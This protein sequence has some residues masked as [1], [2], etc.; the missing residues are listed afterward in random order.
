MRICVIT[1]ENFTERSWI[2]REEKILR[3]LGFDVNVIGLSDEKP[4]PLIILEFRKIIKELRT[5]DIAITWFAL[6]SSI[7]LSSALG[8]P[9][10]ANSV[11]YEVTCY[12]GRVNGIPCNPIWRAL[13]IYALRSADEIIAISK[14]SLKWAHIWS[15]RKGFVI[16][17]G[18][19]I[20]SY[21]CN[22]SQYST[23]INNR[24]PRIV[25]ISFLGIGNIIRKDI[26]TL[27]KAVSLVKKTYPNVKLYIIGKKMEGYVLLEKIARILGV[28]KNVIFTDKVSHEKLLEILCSSDVFVMTSWHEGFPTAA[29]EAAAAGVPV[30]VS[31]RPAMNEVFSHRNAI[32]VPPGN[33][34]ELAQAIIRLLSDKQLAKTLSLQAKETVKKF[35]IENR[36]INLSKFLILFIR[37]IYTNKS[38]LKTYY[39]VKIHKLFVLI[40]FSLTIRF[41]KKTYDILTIISNTLYTKIR[42]T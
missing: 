30:I 3:E 14:E 1:H 36:K 10:V 41:I 8:I 38:K 17:E 19:N 26:I 23:A 42:H 32:I 28:E 12:P 21:N 16:Y 9:V 5:C 18:I 2:V 29:C 22:I 40:L 24:T 37:N 4:S 13:V 25:T 35:D 11:G 31:N 33:H 27:I 6:P 15:G 7:L 20:D 39:K 34:T